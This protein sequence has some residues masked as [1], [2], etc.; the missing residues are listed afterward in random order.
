[1]IL[2]DELNTAAVYFFARRTGTVI[3]ATIDED[4]RPHTAPFNYI[5]V[6]DSRHLRIA[7]SRNHQTY[8]NIVNHGYVALAIVDEGDLAV[9]VKGNVRVLCASMNSNPDMAM[10]EVEITEIRGNNSPSH[11]VNQGIRIHH[12]NELKLLESRRIFI[13]LGQD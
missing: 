8:A 10:I 7:I 2:G 13:E 5:C 3:L 11:C 4:L 1:M 6:A 12:R 9:C